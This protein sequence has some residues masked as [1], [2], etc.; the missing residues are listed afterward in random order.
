MATIRIKYR[1]ADD[2][3]PAV[4]AVGEFALNDFSGHVYIGT[5]AG[6]VNI[7]AADR[8]LSGIDAV[9]IGGGLVSNAEFGYLNG[10]TSGIQS[11]F[12]GKSDTGHTH[13]L[14]EVTDAGNSAGLDVGTGAGSVA[15]GDHTHSP[16]SLDGLSDTTIVSEAENDLLYYSGPTHGWRNMVPGNL[17]VDVT[18]FDGHL[19]ASETTIQLA[20]DKIDDITITYQSAIA[21]GNSGLV[22]AAPGVPAAEFLQ[23]DGTW[24]VPAYYTHPVAD[25]EKHVPADGGTND[26]KFLKATAVAGTYEWGGVDSS[27]ITLVTASFGGHL[28]AADTNIQLALDTLD[29]IVVHYTA[30]VDITELQ[31]TLGMGNS[32]LVPTIGTAGHFL[33]HDGTFGIPAYY[34]HPAADGDLHVPAT[35]TTNE[36]KVLTAGATAGEFY[37]LTAREG[38]AAETVTNDTTN[39]DGLFSA[40]TTNI[41]LALDVVDDIVAADIPFTATGNLEATDVQAALQE[42]DSEKLSDGGIIDGGTF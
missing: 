23:Y 8:L 40:A 26:G 25:G 9:K 35:S 15:A 4:L 22:P 3:A 36:G 5:T 32:A 19:S 7:L 41:Q 42:L 16:G 31:T 28:S 20:L 17:A 27:S 2:T 14:S 33:Q 29:D 13:T 37:W 24:S 6:V 38:G 1:S 10:V 12:T 30:A 34:T 39:F 21:E 11:Q 18:N